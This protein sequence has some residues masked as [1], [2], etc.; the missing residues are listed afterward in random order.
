MYLKTYVKSVDPKSFILVTNVY[1]DKI[2]RSMAINFQKESVKGFNFLNKL[3][4]DYIGSEKIMA[5][6]SRFGKYHTTLYK[7]V[8]KENYHNQ[9]MRNYNL[10][11]AYKDSQKGIKVKR[12]KK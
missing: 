8:I 7:L 12:F 10:I 2:V 9:T 6:N 4:V 11:T 1:G 3:T 5:N